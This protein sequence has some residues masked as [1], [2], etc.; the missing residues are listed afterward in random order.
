MIV[1]N[2]CYHLNKTLFTKPPNQILTKY[3]NPR[4]VIMKS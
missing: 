1:Y 4:S 2:K 3:V